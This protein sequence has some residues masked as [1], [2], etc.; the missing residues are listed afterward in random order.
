[1]LSLNNTYSQEELNNFETRNN[2]LL[3]GAKFA[4]VPDEIEDEQ[5][6]IEAQLYPEMKTDV[7]YVV[8]GKYDGIATSLH[9]EKGQLKRALQRGDGV[10]GE[11]ITDN[12]RSF[13]VIPEQVEPLFVVYRNGQDAVIAEINDFE[14]RGIPVRGLIDLYSGEM[15][16]SKKEF[17]AVNEDREKQFKNARNLVA[18]ML[19]LDVLSAKQTNKHSSF[20]LLG[21]ANL[22][23]IAYTFFLDKGQSKKVK[24]E[25]VSKLP[26]SR[27]VVFESPPSQYQNLKI[28]DKLGFTPD[29]QVTLCSSMTEVYNRLKQWEQL[30]PSFE[31]VMD[32]CVVKVNSLIQQAILGQVSRAPRWA[33]AFKF[34][35]EQVKTKLLGI[36]LQ[37][38]RTGK[39]TP[40]AELEPVDLQGSTIARATLHNFD[41]MIKQGITI[42]SMV[43][44]E[45]G[46]D[47]IP[48]VSGRATANENLTEEEKKELKEKVLQCLRRDETGNV[49]C[50]CM[51]AA[52]LHKEPGKADYFCVAPDCPEQRINRITHFTSRKAMDIEG[53]STATLNKLIEANLIENLADI[54]NL[55][56]HSDDILSMEG[57]GTTK[58]NNLLTAIRNSKSKPYE[59]VLYAIGIP[60]V[61]HE[62]AVLLAEKFPS[63]DTLMNSTIEDL[64]RILR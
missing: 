50:P 11:D 15:M 54:Y 64:A 31:F 32:G 38:G 40:V 22:N 13:Q 2:K 53:L 39:V 33:V 43:A 21:K 46:G 49:L 23:F 61:G 25:E 12:I 18:G 58:L 59:K 55:E 35:A 41:Y 52:P 47:V 8:E 6:S 30:R 37:V 27:V 51:Y 36:T 24:W 1:M 44:V 45:K 20:D 16:L 62:T 60:H 48:K 56:S 9:Y 63:I 26:P 29:K 57:W 7:E 28:M 3:Q 19:R 14:I 42:G 10:R 17:A 34:A 5:L 4:A